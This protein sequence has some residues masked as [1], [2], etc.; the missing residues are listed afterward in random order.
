MLEY[1]WN[2]ITQINSL[3]LTSELKVAIDLYIQ[4]NKNVNGFAGL[5]FRANLM[6]I[7]DNIKKTTLLA[8]LK[9]LI[10]V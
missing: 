10:I 6:Y 3:A 9:N 2:L 7:I 1:S 8:E 4:Q 5:Y